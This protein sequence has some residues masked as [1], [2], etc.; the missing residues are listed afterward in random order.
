MTDH[1]QH[2]A[3]APEIRAWFDHSPAQI[4]IE[5]AREGREPVQIRL[6]WHQARL[7]L[8]ALSSAPIV[9]HLIPAQRRDDITRALL[10]AAMQ[11]LHEARDWPTNST[12]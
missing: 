7:L 6:D 10:D 1:Q 4:V 3:D 11:E 12:K 9:K 2:Q 5:Q 8:D